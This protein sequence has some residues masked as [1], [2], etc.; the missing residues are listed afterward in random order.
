MMQSHSWDHFLVGT[1]GLDKEG[2]R[3]STSTMSVGVH[4]REWGLK[5][6]TPARSCPCWESA[7]CVLNLLWHCRYG[8][9]SNWF[10]ALWSAS[11]DV[12]I[13]GVGNVVVRMVK[14]VMIGLCGIGQVTCMWIGHVGKIKCW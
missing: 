3:D 5:M 7:F 13:K 6:F 2:L 8:C 11:F 4:V 9:G 14:V 12:A 10:N 1:D